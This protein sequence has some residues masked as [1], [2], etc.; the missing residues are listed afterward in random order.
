[1]YL[2][3]VPGPASGQFCQSSLAK[4]LAGF[5]DLAVFIQRC[6]AGRLEVMKLVL[7]RH[8]LSEL[9][10]WRTLNGGGGN[11][12]ANDIAVLCEVM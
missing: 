1:M 9:T 6:S 4:F 3:L 7:D 2:I 10:I 5:L 11:M 8:R 12:V